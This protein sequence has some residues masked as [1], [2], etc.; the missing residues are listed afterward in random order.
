[1]AVL[2]E[3]YEGTD[4]IIENYAIHNFSRKMMSFYGEKIKIEIIPKNGLGKIVFSAK[5]T[6]EQAAEK[7]IDS[8]Q[9][10]R[11]KT[12]EIALLLRKKILSVIKKPLPRD[13]R[14]QHVFDGEVEVPK[15]VADFFQYLL[16]AQGIIARFYLNCIY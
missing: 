4:I 14:L 13:L 6:S 7:A 16:L 11:K 1:M 15:L 2:E 8:V 12:R 10:S 9:L 5:I 3:F